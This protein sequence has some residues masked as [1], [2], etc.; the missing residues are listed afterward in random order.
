MSKLNRLPRRRASSLD[1]PSNHSSSHFKQE[2]SLHNLQDA[3]T[4]PPS[5]IMDNRQLSPFH[6]ARSRT[7]SADSYYRKSGGSSTK[8]RVSALLN[9]PS[10]S[11]ASLSPMSSNQ[12]LRDAASPS[13]QRNVTSPLN[14][15]LSSS[16]APSPF[17]RQQNYSPR[18]QK[19]IHSWDASSSSSP[20]RYKNTSA[21]TASNRSN[22]WDCGATSS[23]T[24]QQQHQEVPLEAPSTPAAAAA[25][26]TP[27]P[28]ITSSGVNTWL[29]STN[30]NYNNTMIASPPS[31][32]LSSFNPNLQTSVEGEGAAQFRS[33]TFRN[34]T[35]LISEE[36]AD[37]P[38]HPHSHDQEEEELYNYMERGAT[39]SA[40][41]S[42]PPNRRSFEFQNEITSTGGSS[43]RLNKFHSHPDATG[44]WSYLWCNW[45]PINPP[46]R[47]PWSRISSAIVRNAPCFWW[48][49]SP[50]E[51][52]ATDR[53]VLYRLNI[54]CAVFAAVQAAVG[55]FLSIV[56]I[57]YPSTNNNSIYDEEEGVLPR[58]SDSSTYITDFAEGRINIWELNI[59]LYVIA[60][61]S[62]VLFVVMI[63]TLRVIRQVNILGA[64][65][66]MWALY[67]IIPI[68]IFLV[69]SLF[70]Y[71]RVTNVWV[72]HW[73]TSPTM[74]W[75]RTLFCE[76]DTANAE[77]MV[78]IMGGEDFDTEDEW[79]LFNFNSTN[80]TDIRGDAEMDSKTLFY[81]FYTVNGIWG[82][83]LVLLLI[84]T[85]DVLQGIITPPIVKASKGA[86][87]P[88]WLTLPMS[89]CFVI[90]CI[91]LFAPSS[92]LAA[93]NEQVRWTGIAYLI[94]AGTFTISAL[95]GWFLAAFPVT[96]IQD[97][98]SKKVAVHLFIFM[99][100]LTI[101]AIGKYTQ[102]CTL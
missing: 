96:N 100:L 31:S 75:I 54:L 26:L 93:A 88:L 11:T 77:C 97:K 57:A 32:S 69:I 65:R 67:W 15:S 36:D 6:Q 95:L 45:C 25:P 64:V 70:D 52:S 78:P 37:H 23:P 2:V 53:A 14:S 85:L 63:C 91:F 1:A 66:Y 81:F 19:T 30:E 60:V 34:H 27:P 3:P 28:G 89:G 44:C 56:L 50:L 58:S 82:A 33:V 43:P 7:H 83:L 79:C 4:P 47:L 92:S 55:I 99:M 90:G 102:F 80:C 73:W 62:V 39:T 49:A 22:S 9:L 20:K 10:L 74:D 12:H 42:S 61:V 24:R 35:S 8:K 94:A 29:G 46:K 72:R 38:H 16:S 71:H 84:M 5:F 59:M 86:N 13:S 48:C 76:D 51:T 40:S 17:T 87:I 68:H 101:A 21:F 41:S 18:H 98:R